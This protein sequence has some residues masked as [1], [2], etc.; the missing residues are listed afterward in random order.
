MMQENIGDTSK[1]IQTTPI[2]D[3]RPQA[4]QRSVADG[5]TDTHQRNAASRRDDFLPAASDDHIHFM[6]FEKT[7]Q[8]VTVRFRKDGSLEAVAHYSDRKSVV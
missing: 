4:A 7:F 5:K 3:D 2:A 8:V 1:K 6:S